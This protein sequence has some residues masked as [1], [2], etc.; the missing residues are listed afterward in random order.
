M[1]IFVYMF[2]YCVYV[3]PKNV[4]IVNVIGCDNV[5]IND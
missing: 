4:V 3:A 5:M 1:Q 2:W